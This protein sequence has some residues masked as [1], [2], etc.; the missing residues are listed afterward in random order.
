MERGAAAA[1]V[2]VVQARQVIVDRELM[3]ELDRG[4]EGE[5]R[6]D[7]QRATAAKACQQRSEAGRL[8]GPR[9]EYF[10]AST[11]LAGRLREE[12]DSSM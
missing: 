9:A 10:I 8:P 12:R 3:D 7:L 6:S 4:G 2:V 11:R 1:E 5:T